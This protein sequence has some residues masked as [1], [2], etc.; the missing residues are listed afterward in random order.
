MKADLFDMLESQ[1]G[2]S[3]FGNFAENCKK[4]SSVLNGGTLAFPFISKKSRRRRTAFTQVRMA[5]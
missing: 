2:Q 4:N 1:K 5:I 3:Q